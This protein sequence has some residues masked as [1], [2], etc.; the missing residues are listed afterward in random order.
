MR[1]E[2]MAGGNRSY[3]YKVAREDLAQGGEGM[4]SRK[5]VLLLSTASAKAQRQ[6]YVW[7]V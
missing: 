3:K 4:I 7:L 2:S 5:C 6:R 1:V